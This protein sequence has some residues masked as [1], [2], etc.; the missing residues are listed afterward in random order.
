MLVYHNKWLSGKPYKKQMRDYLCGTAGVYGY[1]A[2]KG[3]KDCIKIV[4]QEFG[5]EFKSIL[6]PLSQLAHPKQFLVNAINRLITIAHLL[7]CL[8][9]AGYYALTK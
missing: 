7:V 4:S 1:Y 2:F 6:G 8:G 5:K 9:A 3:N